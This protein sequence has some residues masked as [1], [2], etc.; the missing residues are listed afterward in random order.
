LLAPE[1]YLNEIARMTDQAAKPNPPN[2]RLIIV[3]DEVA[4]MK[5]L[6]NTLKDQ[7]YETSGFSSATA[8]VAALQQQKFDLIL[9]DMMM[10]EMDGISLLRAALKTDADLVGIIM[11]GEG[12]IATAVEAMKS[13]A[14]DYILKPFKLSAILPVLA[15]ALSVRQLRIQNLE[16]ET[17]IRKRTEELEEANKEL[18]AFSYSVSHDLRAPLR[19]ITG[20]AQALRDEGQKTEETERHYVNAICRS[21]E[22]MSTLINDLLAFSRTNRTEMRRRPFKTED[23]VREVINEMS[24]DTKDRNIEWDIAPLP[25][26]HG[27]RALLK[28]VWVNLLSNAVKYSRPRNPAKI[29]ISAAEKNGDW[30]FQVRDNGVGMDMTHAQN[31]FGVFQRFHDAD[32]F[33]GTGI[34]LANVRRVVLRHG[35][36]TWAES[37]VDKGTAMFFTLPRAERKAE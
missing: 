26:V 36:K 9:T 14:F 12:T 35:G 3:D 30:E 19:H 24:D 6:C 31:L 29:A 33:E 18:E 4:Q 23:L 13:G 8:A 37:E 27:D 16:L 32:E 15:R 20:Y 11:T 2:A 34:G 10:P 7:G 1:G 25:E 28:Q 17:R 5:A 22:R 21:A